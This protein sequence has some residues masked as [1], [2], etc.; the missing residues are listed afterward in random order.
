MCLLHACTFE[1]AYTSML[2]R[3]G[4]APFYLFPFFRFFYRAYFGDLFSSVFF[5]VQATPYKC[6]SSTTAL[7]IALFLHFSSSN[8]CVCVCVLRA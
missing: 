5:S 6:A 8:L 4:L 1:N 7:L 3:I 2:V